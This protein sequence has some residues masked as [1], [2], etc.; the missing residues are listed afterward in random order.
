MSVLAS[1]DAGLLVQVVWT[2]MLAGIGITAIFSLLVYS[3]ARAGESRR[4]GNS[5]AAALYVGLTTVALLA[6]VG[7]VVL[8]VTTMLQK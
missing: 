2:S 6:F 7:A 5:S 8:G 1:V 3:G 4:A